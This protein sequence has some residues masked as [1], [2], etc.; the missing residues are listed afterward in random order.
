MFEK[1]EREYILR[2]DDK[3]ASIKIVGV[4]GG[5]SNA[6][7]KMLEDK[8]RGIEFIVANTDKQALKDSSVSNKI[9]LG[10]NLTKGLGAGA[11]PEI[12]A[13]SATESIDVI[14]NALEGA[15]LVFVAAGMGGGTGTGA[16]PIIAKTAKEN[17][18]L[19]VGIVTTPFNFEGNI[20][21]H[22][23][24]EGLAALSK[25]V[26]S[27]I[28][29]S[30]N[31]LLHEL[32]GIPLTDSFQ[33]ADAILKQAVRT[34]TDLITKH[35]LIN[36]DFADI[37]AVLKD[38]GLALIG[39][40]KASGENAAVEA[41]IQAI[42]SP[43]LES[44]IEGANHAIVNVLGGPKALTI[45]QA[46]QAVQTIKEAS[47]TSSIDVIFGVTIDENMGDEIV[48]S[49]IATGITNV[50]EDNSSMKSG[51]SIADHARSL[52]DNETDIEK[53]RSGFTQESEINSEEL[54]RELENSSAEKEDDIFSSL[55]ML[56]DEEDEDDM[57]SIE[58]MLK[59]R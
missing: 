50:K 36:L 31:R 15:D 45:N 57:S 39:T 21:E 10:E 42:N 11:N 51:S 19:V 37:K 29:I 23:A 28:I 47:S 5:G 46:Q 55:G 40:G 43:I 34:I 12:G 52:F 41:A 54:K 8:I 1:V 53:Y 25:E 32:G 49:V 59:E 2:N 24:N 27:V 17:G 16:A 30:N 35:S 44:S 3:I 7:N 14:K 38:K 56:D 9:I 26:D 18:A 33:Y 20:R 48:V 22:N 4:G 6:V 58:E 13:K